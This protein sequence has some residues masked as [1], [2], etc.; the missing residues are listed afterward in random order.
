MQFFIRFIHI[1][2]QTKRA[3]KYINKSCCG[4]NP[5]SDNNTQNKIYIHIIIVVTNCGCYATSAMQPFGIHAAASSLLQHRA[6]TFYP[7]SRKCH[8][9]Q[10]LTEKKHYD[11]FGFTSRRRHRY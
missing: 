4:S 2:N 1:E 10:E 3:I 8:T 11:P 6:F 9:F 5:P 7:T